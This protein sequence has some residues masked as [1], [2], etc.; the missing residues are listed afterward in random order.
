MKKIFAILSLLFVISSY[1]TH[2]R[3]G[4]ITYRYLGGT[5]YEVTITTFTSIA[6]GVYADRDE[7]MIYWGDGDSAILKRTAMFDFSPFRRNKYVGQH[8][9]PGAGEY[10][11][12]MEDPNRNEGV[13]NIPGSV[14]VVFAI[15]TTLKIS[16]VEGNNSTP[17]LLSEPIDFA[18]KGQIFIH[19]PSAYDPDGDSLAYK[20]TTCLGQDGVPIANYSLPPA[21]N[22]LTINV[23]T[24]DLVWDYP[25]EV[26]I[27][28]IAILI[29][30]WRGG[31][32]LGQ[33][34]RDMQIDVKETDNLPPEIT[35]VYDTCIVAGDTLEFDVIATDDKCNNIKLTATGLGREDITDIGNPSFGNTITQPNKITKTFRWVPHCED[36]QKQ[37]YIVVFKAKD[38]GQDNDNNPNNNISLVD[39]K[40]QRI[41][42]IAPAPEIDS[43]LPSTKSFKLYWSVS[44]CTEAK[45]YYIY[46][47]KGHYGF[48]HGYCETGV[49]SYTGY[50]KI[51]TINDVYERQFRDDNN[52]NGLEQGFEYCYMVVA[53]FKDEGESYASQEKCAFLILGNPII[54]KA[55]VLETALDTGK[56]E[57]E[58]SKPK[59]FDTIAAP[60]P[61]K[62]LIYRANDEWG[63]NM[64]LI[65]SLSDINDTTYINT[66]LNTIDSIYA[67]SIAFYNDEPNNRFLIGEPS[68]ASSIYLEP[69]ASDNQ[70]KIKFKRNVPWTNNQFVVYRKNNSSLI[71][72]SLTTVTSDYF[73]N[74]SL[75]NG[76][77]YCYKIKS[78]GTYN[79]QE[80][81]DPIINYSQII[82]T[83]AIDTI[84]SCPPVLSVTTECDSMYNK[85]VWTNPNNTCADDVIY[86]NIWYAPEMNT[87][88]RKIQTINN[89]NDTIYYHY[90][91]LSL[92]GCY[93]ITAV[94]S[95]NNESN[96]GIKYCVD[97]CDYYKLP[98][99]FT[100]NGD[101]QN[102]LF[103]PAPYKFVNKIDLKVFN[104]WGVLVFQTEDP[105]INWN[106]KL[107]GTGKD[108]TDGYYFYICDVYEY[109]LIGVTPRN[110]RGFV[111][112]QRGKGN[113][114]NDE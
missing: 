20:L 84:A 50:T 45:G 32:K 43:I 28:N 70:I 103:K 14:N 80:I 53:F 40:S 21:A 48:N 95:F 62:Y 87:P 108:L 83:E 106:G 110:I 113:N 12:F 81:I 35:G 96:Y 3:A 2:N 29:E 86:Y 11:I 78:I 5:T 74:D 109:R 7:L 77:E 27:Y 36:V 55:S 16:F 88:F 4:E 54:T 56:I 17:V 26:G 65:D 15:K 107:N 102:D 66:N 79:K 46:R 73:I 85:L 61:Y 72:D 112:I 6:N 9:F 92:A 114:N 8:T 25:M 33:I 75:P 69:E 98:N 68:L 34:L 19:N 91:E 63:T 23:Y 31:I 60:G 51:A 10:T 94:D 59:T 64:Q 24:G 37:P 67:Y 22:S 89:P 52:G 47:R 100:P 18:A 71:F 97:N 13:E 38:E 99:I 44:P 76:V 111:H 82:C 93:N 41:K 39:I 1:A 101:G 105:D 49:P 57:I 104:R 90:P 58:W 30:E 42:V